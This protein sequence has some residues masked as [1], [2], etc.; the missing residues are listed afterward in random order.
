MQRGSETLGLMLYD[1]KD[2]STVSSLEQ[3]RKN[4]P[5]KIVTLISNDLDETKKH[6]KTPVVKKNTTIPGDLAQEA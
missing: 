4:N 1:E 5:D 3:V 2:L 6:V